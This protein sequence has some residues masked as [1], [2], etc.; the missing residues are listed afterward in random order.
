MQ[1]GQR[2]TLMSSPLAAAVLEFAERQ[3]HEWNGTPTELLA[4]LNASVSRET[5]RSRG[6]P[7][8]PISLSRRLSPLQAALLA[9][10]I[11]LELRRS[12]ER[13]V[14]IRRTNND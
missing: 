5:Q 3:V 12:K 14:A 7:S 4:E 2:D 6:W 1:E 10:G 11:E 8:N 9:Q 13:I